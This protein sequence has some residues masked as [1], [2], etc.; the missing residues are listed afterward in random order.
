MPLVHVN[1]G[2]TESR[3]AP[4][5]ISNSAMRFPCGIREV[6][7]MK[8]YVLSIL[9]HDDYARTGKGVAPIGGCLFRRESKTEPFGTADSGSVLG[10]ECVGQFG[11]AGCIALTPNPSPSGRGGKG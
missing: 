11:G 2:S 4:M 3:T 7:R 9:T 8:Y 5:L 10:G 6:L 1:G